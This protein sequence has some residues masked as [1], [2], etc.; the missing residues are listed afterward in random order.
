[1]HVLAAF[2]LFMNDERYCIHAYY[3]VVLLH[4]NMACP[5]MTV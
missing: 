3:T 5:M 2:F 1:M 4:N